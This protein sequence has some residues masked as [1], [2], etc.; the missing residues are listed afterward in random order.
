MDRL[1]V[2]FDHVEVDVVVLAERVVPWVRH[3]Q[4]FSAPD[5][6][7]PLIVLVSFPAKGA[8]LADMEAI[9]GTARTFTDLPDGGS[10]LPRGAEQ[11][12]LCITE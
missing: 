9:N 2:D 7:A 1:G 6:N 12:L 11:A 10:T 5:V 8:Y 3:V 4:D